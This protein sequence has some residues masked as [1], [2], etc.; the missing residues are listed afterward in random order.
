MLRSSSRLRPPMVPGPGCDKQLQVDSVIAMVPPGALF[1]E[2]VEVT[3]FQPRVVAQV[4]ANCVVESNLLE[5]R[6]WPGV[7]FHEVE[8]HRCKSAV[9]HGCFTQRSQIVEQ[10]A[11]ARNYAVDKFQRSE[12]LA[13]LM[14]EQKLLVSLRKNGLHPGFPLVAAVRSIN[15]LVAERQTESVRRLVV[16]VRLEDS[17]ADFR[18][19]IGKTDL[20]LDAE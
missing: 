20:G 9:V 10:V 6:H 19:V 16:Q 4:E 8:T 13:K 12:L 15:V 2:L 3:H 17:L 7:F 5:S 14:A 18:D 1:L 11:G